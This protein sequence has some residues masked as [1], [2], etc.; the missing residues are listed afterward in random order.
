M[1]DELDLR[2][3]FNLLIRRK[4]VIIAV[5]LLAVVVVALFGY[6]TAV[7]DYVTTTSLLVLT[8]IETITIR[9]YEISTSRSLAK[10][11]GALTTS[12]LVLEGAAEDA[13]I[14]I[15][16]GRIRGGLN[17][18][19]VEDTEMISITFRS[20]DPEVTLAIANAIANRLVHEVKNY[21]GV[22]NIAVV[23]EATRVTPLIPNQRR[24]VITALVLGLIIG[25]AVVFFLDYIDDNI[26]THH[27]VKKYLKLPV[28]GEIPVTRE[29]VQTFPC[30][31]PLTDAYRLLINNIQFSG[32]GRE[33]KSILICPTN[34]KGDK[35][36]IASNIAIM[37]S[38]GGSSVL[39]VDASYNKPTLHHLFGVSNEKG[40]L[41]ITTE[42]EDLP[43]E[44]IIHKTKVNNLYVLPSGRGKN[45]EKPAKPLTTEK[46]QK[47]MEM[48]TG[49]FDFII[50]HTPQLITYTDVAIVAAKTDGC[51]MVLEYDQTTR[52]EAISA[53][54][55]L[56]RAKSN[57]IGVVLNNV[58]CVKDKPDLQ[59]LK[60]NG[61]KISIF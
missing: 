56:E 49:K 61:N 55:Q 32:I 6:S 43:L 12:R 34:P 1:S 54:E 5:A 29:G 45:K 35:L 18:D 19:Y 8:E 16:Y 53:K 50:F 38:K 15:S 33:A 46:F 7:P 27:D 24:N 40:F 42:E 2:Y 4:L 59:I 47:A 37:F 57:I 52:E 39:L 17:V 30:T 36:T 58:P 11:Y 28:V 13:G 31:D 48:L 26:K 23:D 9:G 44:E 3:L 10:S 22:D 60:R 51:L 14:D 21:F 25:V 20:N 41:N